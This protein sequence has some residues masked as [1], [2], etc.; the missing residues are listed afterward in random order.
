MYY[1]GIACFNKYTQMHRDFA[2][3]CVSAEKMQDR[4]VA[5]LARG[6]ADFRNLQHRLDAKI[7]DRSKIVDRL[8]AEVGSLFAYFAGRCFRT[9]TRVLR[10]GGRAILGS[11]KRC[12]AGIEDLPVPPSLEAA[13][14]RTTTESM[15]VFDWGMFTQRLATEKSSSVRGG[16][17]ELGRTHH[18]DGPGGEEEKHLRMFSSCFAFLHRTLPYVRSSF[19][20]D[21]F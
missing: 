4:I 18:Y 14:N 19:S 20:N 21:Y 6:N 15:L 2:G 3:E 13:L 5:F 1:G 10:L 7:V 11:E 17:H 8:V 12:L 16:R 9:A